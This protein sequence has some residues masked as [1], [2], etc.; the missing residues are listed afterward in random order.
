MEVQLDV[1]VEPVSTAVLLVVAFAGRV[2]LLAV[3]GVAWYVVGAPAEV[4]AEDSK[5]VGADALVVAETGGLVDTW[6]WER[7]RLAE[8]LGN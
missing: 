8:F 5:G 1:A 2:A 7:V 4:V 3:H 6:S